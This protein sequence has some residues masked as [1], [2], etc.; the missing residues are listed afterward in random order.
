[1]M[2]PNVQTRANTSA[3]CSETGAIEYS[4]CKQE[5]L[6]AANGCE[7][8]T[9][10]CVIKFFLQISILIMF[11]NIS[12]HYTNQMRNFGPQGFIGS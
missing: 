1:M 9:T 3:A 7:T 4:D 11:I 8:A 10:Y 2:T 12:Q 5:W 6:L